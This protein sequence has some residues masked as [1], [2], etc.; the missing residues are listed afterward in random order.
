MSDHEAAMLF[1]GSE[2]DNL[3][4]CNQK[5]Q[6]LGIGATIDLPQLVVEEDQSSGNLPCI[7]APIPSLTAT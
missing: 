1:P 3:L 6:E 7:S 4:R 2:L 5:L